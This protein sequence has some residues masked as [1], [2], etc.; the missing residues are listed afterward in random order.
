MLDR[1][2]PATYFIHV[3]N[4]SRPHLS[5]VDVRPH[6]RRLLLQLLR[7]SGP[8]SRAHLANSSGL[9]PAAITNVV[10]DLLESGLVEELG[11]DPAPQERTRLG[12]PGSLISLSSSRHAV[13][14]VQI[15]AGFLHVGV[16][17]LKA[18]ILATASASF[19]LPT[20][21]E[22][23]LDHAVVLMKQVLA[24]AGL[25]LDDILG[26]GVGAPGVVDRAQ[27]VNLTSNK[28]DWSDVPIADHFEKALGVGV[29]IDHNVRAM[30]M[31]EVRYGAGRDLE[32]LA[33]VYIR[34]G[35]GAGLVLGGKEYRGGTH[36]SVELGHLRVIPAGLAC[37]CGGRGCLETVAT[38]SA[39][40]GQLLATV[41]GTDAESVERVLGDDWTKWFVESVLAGNARSVRVRDDL[42]TS[43]ASALL[44][45]IN[46]LNPERIVLG[47]LLGDLSAIVLQP[48][49]DATFP[50]VMPLVRDSVTI[51]ESTFGPNAGLIGAATVA[52]DRYVFGAPLILS[53][54]S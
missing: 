39:I 9:S 54:A 46:L 44:N 28:L 12:R 53:H 37:E 20:P 41:L 40:R 29:V 48:L 38:D 45:V 11:A 24:D 52:L 10:S 14:S 4:K 8:L 2:I 31:G 18:T 34:S 22:P 25:S 19:K 26:I 23:V 7:S 30:A 33:F 16:C 43:L 51:E 21:A 47:G 3:Q 27:R 50:Q 32:S 36:G 17:D 15:G 5:S 13:L 6:N 49:R 42:V 35:V 1:I